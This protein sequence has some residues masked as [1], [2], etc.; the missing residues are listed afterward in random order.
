[1]LAV[2][3]KRLDPKGPELGG[4]PHPQRRVAVI[5]GETVA[6]SGGGSGPAGGCPGVHQVPGHRISAGRE[7]EKNAES[8]VACYPAS[9]FKY[10]CRCRTHTDLWVVNLLYNA[11]MFFILFV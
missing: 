9:F 5:A 11:D 7:R 10:N 6:A 1:M 2:S 4:H 3:G 8:W